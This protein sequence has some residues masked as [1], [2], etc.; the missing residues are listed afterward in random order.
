MLL[1]L[2]VDGRKER[3]I[4]KP[5]VVYELRSALKHVKY[6]RFNIQIEEEESRVWGICSF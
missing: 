1:V 5:P 3:L 4:T 6:F 2:P